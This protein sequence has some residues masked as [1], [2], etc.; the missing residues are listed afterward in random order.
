VGRFLESKTAPDGTLNLSLVE[1][2]RLALV[3]N[4]GLKAAREELNK[5]Q[6]DA[7]SAFSRM[8]PQI[9]VSGTYVRIDKG[10]TAE[11]GGMKINLSPE[12]R[13]SVELGITQPLFQGGQAYHAFK[14]A[15]IMSRISE[16]GLA[17]AREQV[18]YAATV[19]FYDAL[20]HREAHK[21]SRENLKL[22]REHLDNVRKRLKQGVASN[23]EKLRAETHVAGQ[24]TREIQARNLL[25]IKKLNLAR[26]AGLPL[27][28]K[29]RPRGSI[30]SSPFEVDYDTALEMARLFRPDL[31][32]GRLGV[33]AVEKQIDVLRAGLMPKLYGF[34]NWGWERPSSKSFVAGAGAGYWNGG[35]SLSVPVF[36]GG[37]THS[38]LLKAYASRRQARYRLED[39]VEEVALEIRKAVLNLSD[40]TK[41]VEASQEGLRLAR[42]GRRLAKVGYENG[43]NTQ[44]DVL[45]ADNALVQAKFGYLQA[46]FGHIMAREALRRAMGWSCKIADPKRVPGKEPKKGED[47]KPKGTDE[48]KGEEGKAPEKPGK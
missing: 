23:F 14:A 36:D 3:R 21:V 45:D 37:A 18:A 17:T 32:V 22:A 9:N 31:E 29:L 16:L 15:Q 10:A 48:A 40:A 19:S 30:S 27:D 44:L 46:I 20:L 41:A 11:I 42:E 38:Q 24:E 25:E 1:T 47:G 28:V 7:L 8:L 2:V 12:D 43:V 34:F 39:M 6:G 5:A 13:Y 33:L 4:L 26:V 35:V